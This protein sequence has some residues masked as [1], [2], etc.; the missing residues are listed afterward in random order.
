MQ[1]LPPLAF[2]LLSLY[3]QIMTG[4]LS[5][6]AGVLGQSRWIVASQPHNIQHRFFVLAIPYP[7]FVL[8]TEYL[9]ITHTISLQIPWNQFHRNILFF[10]TLQFRTENLDHQSRG[11]LSEFRVNSNMPTL[12][13]HL[14]AIRVPQSRLE[15]WKLCKTHGGKCRIGLRFDAHQANRLTVI[16]DKMSAS[17]SSNKPHRKS[18]QITMP[19]FF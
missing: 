19:M 12:P 4:E 7:T 11:L 3:L 17:F 8:H 15:A 18:P 14:R 6:R 9:T 13:A 10:E 1:L 5:C 16:R 2:T